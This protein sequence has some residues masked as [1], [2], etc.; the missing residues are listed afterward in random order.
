MKFEL[1]DEL[2][3]ATRA[4]LIETTERYCVVLQTLLKPPAISVG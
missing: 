4:E 2:D 3:V 1:G